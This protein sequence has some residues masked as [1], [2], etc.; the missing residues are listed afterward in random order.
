MRAWVGKYRSQIALS[1]AF[2][3][4]L[5][6]VVLW[7]DPQPPPIAIVEPTPRPTRTPAPIA[8]YVT[9]AVLRPD[10]YTLPE[11]SRLKDALL[12]AGGA[13]AEADL[14]ALNLAAPLR[15]GERV[16]V[17]AQGAAPLSAPTGAQPAGPVN[18]NRATAAEL[19]ALPGLGPT[20]AQ[21]IVEDR[22]ANGPYESVDQLLRV[23]G[24]GPALLEKLRPHVAVR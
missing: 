1:L 12:A 4:A 3:A 6:G 11:G 2:A 20:L 13:T 7:R 15:D 14:D 19:E 17:P 9:G 23:R 5:G 24:I 21:R 18:I 10:V 8:V 16:H 22:Q